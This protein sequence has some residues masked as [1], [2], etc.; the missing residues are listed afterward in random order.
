MRARSEQETFARAR[1]SAS[2]R[3]LVAVPVLEKGTKPLVVD[4]VVE[5]PFSQAKLIILASG[6]AAGMLAG[7]ALCK[8]LRR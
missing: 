5:A 3:R 4:Y 7:V 6:F 1:T 8:I 2:R